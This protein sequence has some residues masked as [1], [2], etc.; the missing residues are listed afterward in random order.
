MDRQ[1]IFTKNRDPRLVTVRRGGT[2]SD[3]NHHLLTV[4]KRVFERTDRSASL[5]EVEIH[6]IRQTTEIRP[7]LMIARAGAAAAWVQK[8]WFD[9]LIQVYT[10]IVGRSYQPGP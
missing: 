1:V 2:L 9:E 8:S 6:Y 4:Q 5:V 10:I 3:A 7:I